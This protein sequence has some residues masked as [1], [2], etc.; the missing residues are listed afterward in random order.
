MRARIR[1]K[2]RKP[3]IRY[4]H[5]H[6]LTAVPLDWHSCKINGKELCVVLDDRSRCILAGNEFDAVTAE[7]SI[8]L[9][10]EVFDSFG[11][12]RRIEQVIT[13]HGSQFYA[14]KIDNA[15]K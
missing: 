3:W 7:N 4:E 9:V 8:S 5:E 15:D 6:S 2:R 12:I 1:K 14:N 11:E 10:Q 13:D